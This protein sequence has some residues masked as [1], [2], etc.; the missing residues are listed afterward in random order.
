MI[1]A[2]HWAPC[3]AEKMG[4]IEGF[5]GGNVGAIVRIGNAMRTMAPYA[6]REQKVAS[7]RIA[8]EL[9]KLF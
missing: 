5:A 9:A 8:Y 4:L 1:W 2:A 3:V 6:E 7:L